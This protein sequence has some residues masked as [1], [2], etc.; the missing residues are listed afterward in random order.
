MSAAN[1][2]AGIILFN[3]V[4]S[5]GFRFYKEL[6]KEKGDKRAAGIV[7]TTLVFIVEM[8]LYYY[9]GLFKILVS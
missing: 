6:N 4:F 7:A 8:V 9:L 1:I 5:L 3:A 2:A